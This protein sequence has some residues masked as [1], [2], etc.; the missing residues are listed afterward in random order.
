MEDSKIARG[1]TTL[2][3]PPSI[4]ILFPITTKGKFSGSEGFAYVITKLRSYEISTTLLEIKKD[5]IEKIIQR[6]E[7]VIT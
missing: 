5:K 6:E 2:L 1:H 7:H 4:S 3:F